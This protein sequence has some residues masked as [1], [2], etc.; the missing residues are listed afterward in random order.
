MSDF[1][2]TREQPSDDLCHYGVLGMKWGKRK[3]SYNQ[4]EQ[5]IKKTKSEYKK[6]KKDYNKAYNKSYDYS[7]RH[8]ISQFVKQKQKKE[9]AKLWTDT[10]EK[11]NT[12]NKTRTN[13]KNAKAA[14]KAYKKV[15]NQKIDD[16][17]KKYG[18]LEDQVTY[19]KN[20]NKKLNSEIYKKMDDLEKEIKR[21]SQQR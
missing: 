21:T 2:I 11:A 13:Y 7:S 20:E 16:M 12:L 19:G 10:F 1:I 5:N 4:H 3:A 17:W 8:L 18:A 14:K 6:A 9:S 15:Q